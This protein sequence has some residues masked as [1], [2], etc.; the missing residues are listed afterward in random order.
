MPSAI[1][2]SK[3]MDGVP[4]VKADLRT[5]LL[6]AKNEIEALQ[7]TSVSSVKHYGAQGNGV[8]DDTT[9]IQTAIDAVSAD[10]GGLV[11]VPAGIYSISSSI[12]F[13]ANVLIKGEYGG[14]MIKM[15]NGANVP[16][17]FTS[18]G[19][20]PFFGLHDIMLN[21]NAP[22]QNLDR[23]CRG[24]RLAH[25]ATTPSFGANSPFGN[26][27]DILDAHGSFANVVIASIDG[28]GI[29]TTGG[30]SC[31]FHRIIVN[32]VTGK[33]IWT[34]LNDAVFVDC[35]VSGAWEEGWLCF[36]GAGRYYGCK[37]GFVGMGGA[38]DGTWGNY[39]NGAAFRITN[40]DQVFVGCEG[41]DCDGPAFK[42]QG[43]RAKIIG[44]AA[45]NACNLFNVSTNLGQN[46]PRGG[47][48]VGKRCAVS[49]QSVGIDNEIDVIVRDRLLDT[50]PALSPNL[51]CMI[52]F[53]GSAEGNLCRL[54]GDVRALGAN[55]P[56]VDTTSPTAYSLGNRVDTPYGPWAP[57]R[58]FVANDTTPLVFGGGFFATANTAATTITDF[59]LKKTGMNI[60]ETF[61]LRIADSN[62]TV[63]NGAN[64]V[65]KSGSDITAQGVYQFADINGMWREV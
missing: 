9:A 44:G 63:Q 8:T 30:S 53:V 14:T 33:G 15:A 2:P 31:H 57:A 62:T 28:H 12:A 54:Y 3:P 58:T 16:G 48:Y 55:K 23:V 65:M 24:I 38:P 40:G 32:G 17:M 52:E 22:N 50:N 18:S 60:G 35:K 7:H 6:T 51:D 20:I 47:G 13:K 5:N 36:S 11:F 64:I 43:A 1:D 29:E 39:N 37:G 4:A 19:A 26:G 42:V 45:H 41:M 56:W 27:L 10:G 59:D 34:G 46:P 25:S 61:H 49:V 21:G